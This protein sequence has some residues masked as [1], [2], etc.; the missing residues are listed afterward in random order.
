MFGA[1]DSRQLL[2]SNA[3]G[4]TAALNLCRGRHRERDLVRDKRERECVCVY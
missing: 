3:L 1:L 4:C 2:L